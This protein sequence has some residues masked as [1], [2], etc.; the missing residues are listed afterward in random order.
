LQVDKGSSSLPL[1]LRV[2]GELFRF[3][4]R[5]TSY[6]IFSANPTRNLANP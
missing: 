6:T 1:P 2:T 4:C 5:K 3:A